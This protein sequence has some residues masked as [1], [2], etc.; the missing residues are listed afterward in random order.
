MPFVQGLQQ[1]RTEEDTPHVVGVV[2]G[3]QERE[4]IAASKRWRRSPNS[5]E[6]PPH[7][8]YPLQS[9]SNARL[10]LAATTICSLSMPSWAPRDADDALFAVNYITGIT[11]PPKPLIFHY[12]VARLFLSLSPRRLWVHLSL[13]PNTLE[14]TSLQLSLRKFI[15]LGVFTR[16]PRHAEKRA[17]LLDKQTHHKGEVGGPLRARCCG[18]NGLV[19][20]LAMRTFIQAQPPIFFH[21]LQQVCP[22]TKHLGCEKP[23]FTPLLG[24]QH[25]PFPPDQR[26]VSAPQC[27]PGLRPPDRSPLG[28]NTLEET[29]LQ[30]SLRKFIFWGVFT[31]NPR[32]AEKRAILLALPRPPDLGP[33]RVP[34][35]SIGC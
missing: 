5:R 18:E 13:G 1:N 19:L 3:V 29:S 14:E 26:K 30:L 6:L 33:V 28:P 12:Q 2:E 7:R 21:A 24:P 16:N 23:E 15:F 20:C 10:G 4:E 22:R 32:H 17:I 31:R 35:S 27:P 25:S 9:D 11:T 34:G 8:G